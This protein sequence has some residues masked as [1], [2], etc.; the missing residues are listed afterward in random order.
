[1][2]IYTWR[3]KAAGAAATTSESLIRFE[4]PGYVSAYE[5]EY[6]QTGRYKFVPRCNDR[7]GSANSPLLAVYFLPEPNRFVMG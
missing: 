7:E 2:H 6:P 5:G 3:Y 4:G 1:M